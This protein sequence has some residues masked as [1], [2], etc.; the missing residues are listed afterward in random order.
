[1]IVRDGDYFGRTVNV[2]ARIAARAGP[3][4]VLVGSD[5][6]DVA[7][8]PSVRFDAVGPVSLKGI[9]SPVDLYR[10]LRA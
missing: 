2:A 3:G 7:N 5:L 9:E 8:R 4:E 10:A 1:V 6:V